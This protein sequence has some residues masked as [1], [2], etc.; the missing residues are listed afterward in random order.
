[1]PSLAVD[2]NVYRTAKRLGFAP[3]SAN[4][5]KVKE[6]I[7]SLIPKDIEIYRAVHTYLLALG[8][9]YCKATP[10]CGKCPVTEWCRYFK[11][12]QKKK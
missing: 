9:Y 12:H 11:K 3:S 2:I 10:K 5:K 6:I 4:R 8:K 7:E 1:M